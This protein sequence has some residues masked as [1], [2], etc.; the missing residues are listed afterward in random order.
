V[1]VSLGFTDQTRIHA[2]VHKETI[3][4]LK[5][6]TQQKRAHNCD[7][8]IILFHDNCGVH[9]ARRVRE[10]IDECGF[11]EMEHRPYSPDL[12]QSDYYVFPKLKKHLRG[13]RFSS[14]E[15]LKEA[16]EKCF[17]DLPKGFFFEGIALLE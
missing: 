14:D 13:R 10:V 5:T 17:E 8:K 1:D 4:K 2:E 6:A 15:Y 11:V 9:K 3:R 12:A 16:V 7:Q